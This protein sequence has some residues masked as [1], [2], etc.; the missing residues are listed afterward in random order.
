VDNEGSF[1]TLVPEAGEQ[2]GRL[3]DLS[4]FRVIS[5]STYERVMAL[6]PASLKYALRGFGLSEQELDAAGQRLTH[7]QAELQK[8]VERYAGVDQLYDNAPNQYEEKPEDNLIEVDDFSF[9]GEIYHR[10]EK[11]EKIEG[12][13][14][15][16]GEL[17]VLEDDEFNRLN[18]ENLCAVVDKNTGKAAEEGENLASGNTFYEAYQGTL[19]IPEAARQQDDFGKKADGPTLVG[20]RNRC[21]P[22][23]LRADAMAANQISLA[24]DGSTRTFHSSGKYRDLQRAASKYAEYSRKLF[25]RIEQA[26]D[27]KLKALPNYKRDLEAILRP[28]ELKKLRELG[29]KLEKAAQTYLDNKLKG[30]RTEQDYEA[31]TQRRI[32][33]ARNALKLGKRD[34]LLRPEEEDAARVNERQAKENLARRLG[35]RAEEVYNRK[36]P[37]KKTDEGLSRERPEAGIIKI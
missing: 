36:H 32:E 33:N 22:E 5:R 28:S 2:G 10:N 11:G 17:R 14:L 19:R 13:K 31:Y 24:L 12:L 4:N 8:S 6:D 34:A 30:G 27:P 15:K 9:S 35:D 18:R 20:A 21:V 26:N 1:G 7:L 25:R 16:P 23:N 37:P 29:S 3:P